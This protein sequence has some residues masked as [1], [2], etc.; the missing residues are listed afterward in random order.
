MILKVLGS[1]SKGNCYLLEAKHEA[2]IIEAGLPFRD[3]QQAIDFNINKIKGCIVSHE[4][5][6]HASFVHQYG[7]RGIKILGTK[8]TIKKTE[9]NNGF[10]I[11]NGNYYYFGGFAV[12]PFM[13][14]HD[15]ECFG[16]QVIHEEIGVLI[17]ATD[18]GK[19]PYKFEEFDYC[20][21]E[22][23]YSDEILEQNA[24]KGHLSGVQINRLAD[25]HL[26]INKAVTWLNKQ[27]KATIK[28]AILIHL[29]SGNSNAVEFARQFKDQ[30]GANTIIAEKGL[31]V[32][33]NK[34]P[35]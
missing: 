35:F 16:F 26:S 17:F 7:K 22:S 1:S 25:T 12:V 24:I 10:I 8:N 32:N 34:Y 33:L 27:K 28:A 21:I 31:T 4:H 29:S 19:M 2:L 15:V 18:T 30:T 3:V 5:G 13:L 11:Q 9:K 14:F 20:L 6:D 23:N